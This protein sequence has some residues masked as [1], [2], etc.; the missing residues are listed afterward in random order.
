MASWLEKAFEYGIFRGNRIAYENVLDKLK[1]EYNGRLF[2]GNLKKF[3]EDVARASGIS[4]RQV[5]NIIQ[6]LR[7]KGVLDAVIIDNKEY[8]VLSKTFGSRLVKM[9]RNYWDWL[10]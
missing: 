10:G 1:I 9:G 7:E 8:L 6:N 3:K 2:V 5:H 4:E